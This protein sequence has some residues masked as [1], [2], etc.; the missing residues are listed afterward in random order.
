MTQGSYILF[1]N[2]K[3]PV[4]LEVG[5][6]GKLFFPKSVYLYFGS[7]LGPS[8]KSLELRIRRHYQK[9]KKIQWHIDYL[10][11]IQEVKPIFSAIFKSKSSIECDLLQY[12]RDKKEYSISHK[13]FGSSDCSNKCNSHLLNTK[14]SISEIKQDIIGVSKKLKLTF[15]IVEDF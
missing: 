10:T 15:E 6:L 1:L 14:K 11:S 7:A 2:L 13:D 8:K 9:Q 4:S 5:S 12:F 3:K